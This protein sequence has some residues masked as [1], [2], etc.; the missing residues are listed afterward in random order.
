MSETRVVKI[1][2][3][4]T[5]ASGTFEEWSETFE[6]ARAEGV[7]LKTKK[8]SDYSGP[9]IQVDQILYYLS[10]PNELPVLVNTHCF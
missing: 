2:E 8:F 3:H 9:R 4:E 1:G 5:V 7:S 10:Y 6:A